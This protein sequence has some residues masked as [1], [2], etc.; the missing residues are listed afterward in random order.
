MVNE[1]FRKGERIYLREVRMSDV[2]QNY[3]TWLNSPET[4]QYLESRYVPQSLENI[5]NY[6]K[7]RDGKIDEVF[8]AICWKNN[9]K[10]I[11][12]IKLGPVN[13]IHRRAD[14]GLL[15]GDKEYRGRGVATEA[16]QLV[17]EYA[18]NILNLHKI[19]AG[20]HCTNIGSVKAFQKAGFVIEGERKKHS[21][22]NGKY[23][24][25]VLWGLLKQDQ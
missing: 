21:F 19:T 6:V 13:W 25:T 12:N 1:K 4:N 20:S 7:S 3:Y 9:Q 15:I 8:F 11:G 17:V 16:I 23:V 14:I 22:I 10:H 24:D 18:F 2:N 5:S